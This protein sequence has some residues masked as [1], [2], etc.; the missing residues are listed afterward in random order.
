MFSLSSWL[1]LEL[2]SGSGF[3]VH[4]CSQALV[5]GQ[6]PYSDIMEDEELGFRGN[7]DIY[8][9]EADRKLLSSCMGLMKASKACLKKVLGVVKAHGKADSP[10]QIAQLDDIADIANE[11][12]P[13]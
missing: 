5:E 12:S 2:V 9:S 8:W 4:L 1:L 11:I 6:D 13:R 10:D 7:R 3:S